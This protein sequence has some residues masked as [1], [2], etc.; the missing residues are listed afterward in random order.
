MVLLLLR[1]L[2]M[3][4]KPPA[5]RKFR[6]RIGRCSQRTTEKIN[7]SEAAFRLF[8]ARHQYVMRSKRGSLLLRGLFLYNSSKLMCIQHLSNMNCILHLKSPDLL[9]KCAHITNL[10]KASPTRTSRSSFRSHTV[11]KN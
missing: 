4:Q 1:W 8:V 6:I 7:F 2:S 5:V 10:T 9:C 11:R 3:V